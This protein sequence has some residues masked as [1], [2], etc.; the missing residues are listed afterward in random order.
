MVAWRVQRQRAGRTN[1]MEWGLP[2]RIIPNLEE[3]KMSFHY[4]STTQRRGSRFSGEDD[5][6]TE[7]LSLS[8]THAPKL[9]PQ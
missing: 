5:T 2:L 3:S 9:I 4:N 8:L 1:M 6:I 7:A